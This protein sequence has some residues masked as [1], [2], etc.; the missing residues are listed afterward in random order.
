LSAPHSTNVIGIALSAALLAALAACRAPVARVTPPER[1]APAPAARELGHGSDDWH[2]LLIAPFGSTLK[3]I[4][5]TLHEVLLFR[6]EA[7]GSTAANDGAADA[8]AGATEC[9]AADAPAV[10]LFG[11][12]P[13]EYLLCFQ[14]D[15][16]A[17][18]QAR[19]HLP[20]VESAGVFA[21]AC[22]A[23]LR[24]AEPVDIALGAPACEGRDGP[25]RFRGRLEE[26]TDLSIT[27]DAAADP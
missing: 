12:D 19:V 7:H 4:P 2:G 21:A 18:I 13:D 10:R 25:I 24:N 17:R 1:S 27:L 15:R 5:L 14:Q 23:W 8:A 3:D 26:E 6:D 11:R 16:L 20:A 9:Y 22:A